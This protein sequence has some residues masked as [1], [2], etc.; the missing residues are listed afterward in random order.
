MRIASWSD[1]NPG[2]RVRAQL[3]DTETGVYLWSE[4]FDRAMQDVFAIQEEIARAIV[5]A[6]RVQLAGSTGGSLLAR[7][8]STIGSY[9]YYLKG[10]FHWHKRTPEDMA[11]GVQLFESAI[12]ADPSSALAQTGLAGA[13]AMLVDYGLMSPAEGM[14]LARAAAGCGVELDPE[15]AEAYTALAMIASVY[16]RQWEDAESLYLRAIALNPG[17][18]T[19]HHWYAVD[20]CAMLGRF[21]EAVAGLEIAS[22][23]DPLSASSAKVCRSSRCCSGTTREPFVGNRELAEFDP[24]FYKAYTSLGRVYAQRESMWTRS[25]CLKKAASWPAI[26][27]TS[28]APWDRSTGSRAN[29]GGRGK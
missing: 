16:V 24:A 19:A 10:R 13:Y 8:R 26:S 3:I 27:R 25:P 2:L 17:Y 21:D 20:F 9:D 4:T 23:L 29:R 15:L 12:A 14:P 11:R 7:S 1:G 18:A 22:Q 28:S 6:L 5:R